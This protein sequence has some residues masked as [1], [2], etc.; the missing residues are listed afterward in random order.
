MVRMC[1]PCPLGQG[2]KGL[3][4]RRE[5]WVVLEAEVG[6]PLKME[7]GAVSQSM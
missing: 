4:F 2:G 1:C 3:R 7:E 5:D 6:R